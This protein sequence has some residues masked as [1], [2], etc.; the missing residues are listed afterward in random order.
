MKLNNKILLSNLIL[1]VGIFVLTS[2]G[3]YYLVNDTVYDEL[4]NHLLQHKIDIMRQLRTHPSSLTDIQELGGVG[5]YEWVEI[6]PYDGTVRLNRNSFST[7]DT[8]RSQTEIYPEAYRRLVTTISVN[9]RYYTLRLYEE[10]AAW[11]NISMAILFSVLAGLLIWILLLYLVNQVAFNR[12]LTPFYDTVDK[13]ESISDPTDFNERFPFSSTYEIEVL[14]RALNTM[15]DQI[16]SSFED[17]K[18]FIQNAS[19]ELLTPLSII[20]QKAEKILARSEDLDRKTIESANEI[21]QTAVRLS[22]LS[23]ALLLISRVENRQYELDEQVEVTD[24]T[25]D[26]L[27]ELADFI[28]LKNLSIDNNLDQKIEVEGNRELIQSAIYN[29]VQNAVKFSPADSTIRISTSRENGHEELT[30][31]DV[32]PGIPEMLEGS[33]FDRFRK[34][35]GQTESDQYNGSGLGLSLVKSICKLHGFDY[36]ARNK[37]GGGTEI[38]LLF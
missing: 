30:V 16:R 9:D 15:M 10:V 28:E 18:Q 19:H 11:E 35:R 33:L 22:R 21:Q 20:R 25:R 27:K 6:T 12:I 32:G 5:S 37:E 3:M 14:N 31:S 4:D 13:L 7:I 17:Q 1:S 29:V 8:V 23:N 36:E 24:V 2:I 34:G 26:V 38:T